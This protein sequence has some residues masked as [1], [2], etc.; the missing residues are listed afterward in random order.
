MIPCKQEGITLK[1]YIEKEP[2]FSD[3][4]QLT[5][6]TDPGNADYMNISTKQ[7]FANTLVN[8]KEIREGD[9]K[10]KIITFDSMDSKKADKWTDVAMM[11]SGEK[12]KSLIKKIS[13]MFKNVR[14]LYKLLGTTD[15]SK[16]EDGTV[17]GAIKKV[18]KALK[19]I[20]AEN[21][22]EEMTSI[23]QIT[24]VGFWKIATI[25]NNYAHEIGIDNNVGDFYAIVSNYNGNGTDRYTFG[26]LLLF[27][28]RLQGYHYAI[29][30]W[31]ENAQA[32]LVLTNDNILTTKE[33]INANTDLR[34]I[35]GATAMKEMFSEINSNLYYKSG[36]VIEYRYYLW[37]CGTL[38]GGNKEIWITIPLNKPIL[39]TPKITLTPYMFIVR[40]NGLYLKNITSSTDFIDSGIEVQT[41]G[42][43]NGTGITFIFVEHNGFGGD[44]NDA[45]AVCM[46]Y[47][48][49]FV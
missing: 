5:E 39:G 20:D 17:T 35:A 45:V 6:T 42:H 36:D 9:S 29:N 41:R 8:Q 18:N 13:I 46:A 21:R 16:I 31:N 1:T 24:S 34:N 7:I 49:T 33:Q 40:Q 25:E 10:N 37:I 19:P 30:I 48:I 12:H 23:N 2:V 11:E 44:N 4:I 22:I 3:S 26:D 27:S 14:Y 43:V 47:K 15:I 32:R 38:T 28:P